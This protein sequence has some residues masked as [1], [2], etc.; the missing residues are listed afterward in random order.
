MLNSFHAV[1]ALCHHYNHASL[2]GEGLKSPTSK[3]GK[4]RLRRSHSL[5][6]LPVQCVDSAAKTCFLDLSIPRSQKLF[7]QQTPEFAN[8][9]PSSAWYFSGMRSWFEDP[10]KVRTLSFEDDQKGCSWLALL[11][12]TAFWAASRSCIDDETGNCSGQIVGLSKL[13]REQLASAQPALI[14]LCTSLRLDAINKV[15]HHPYAQEFVDRLCFSV[16]GWLD[17][18]KHIDSRVRR[19]ITPLLLKIKICHMLRHLQL[20]LDR[21]QAADFNKIF[22]SHFDNIYDMSKDIYSDQIP[23]LRCYKLAQI[24]KEFCRHYLQKGHLSIDD[25]QKPLEDYVDFVD[26]AIY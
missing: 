11:R 2:S 7:W 24:L 14:P 1:N 12:Q 9:K 17:Y 26:Q 19:A 25:L 10:K 3:K 21:F 16:E 18:R 5:D 4:S 6:D 13:M 20:Q 8:W 23:T 15:A 22:Y